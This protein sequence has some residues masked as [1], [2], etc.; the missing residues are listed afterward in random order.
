[1]ANPRQRR[2]LR[3]GSYK[4]IRHS[5]RA[6]K[7][8]KKQ[9]PIRGPKVL[10]DAWDR[11]KTVKQNYEALGLVASLNPTASG[12]VE[13]P[14][15]P[16]LADEHSMEVDAAPEASTSTAEGTS[17][18]PKGFGRIVRDEDGNIIDIELAEEDTEEIAE[19]AD[20]LIE[21]I[22]DPSKQ[23]ALAGWVALGSSTA[24]SGCVSNTSDTHVVQSG[25][26][27]D[28][29]IKLAADDIRK[30]RRSRSY[31]FRFRSVREHKRRTNATLRLERRIR[32]AA[33]LGCKTRPRCRRDGEG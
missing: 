16:V 14:L 11:H 31:E 30:F 17:A 19:A 24:A 5:K 15:V 4:P 9:P 20:R 27:L 2:K 21:D 1:M 23:E 26:Y 6:Q 32:R 10:Q 25:S 28:V 18:L 7:N 8:L 29:P 33:A 12:G 22:P 13:Q 3:S